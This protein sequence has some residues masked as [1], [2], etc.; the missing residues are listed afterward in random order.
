MIEFWADDKHVTLMKALGALP[1][2]SPAAQC[3]LMVGDFI[4]FPGFP[5]QAFRVVSRRFRSGNQPMWL[6]QLE[7]AADPLD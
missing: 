5:Q 7:P 2:Q 1:V 3:P 6:L 4:T